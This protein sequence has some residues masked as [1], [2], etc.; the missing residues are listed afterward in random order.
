[1]NPH[2]RDLIK[3]SGVYAIG[4]I[5]TR[6]VS[7][8]ML[9][10]NTRFL[11]PADYGT[12]A[13][14]DLT[15]AILGIVFAGGM[16]SALGRFHHDGDTDE[17]RNVVWWTGLT[18][19]A[20]MTAAFVLPA[21]V[22]RDWI[23]RVTL[24]ADTV[25]AGL[26]YAL[27]LSTLWF[28]VIT[29]VAGLYL[30]IR[31]W[32]WSAVTLGV[33]TLIVNVVLNIYFLRAGWGIT[34]I[35]AGNL[36]TLIVMSVVRLWIVLPYCGRFRFDRDI[37]WQMLRFGLPIM[38][39]SLL[40]TAMQQSDR[41]LL[42]KYVDLESVGVYFLAY[43]IGQGLN[44]LVIGPFTAIWG[45]V[46]FDIARQ[47][48]SKA[49]FARIFEYY[50]Y[51]VLLLMFGVSLFIEPM[52]TLF[53]TPAYLGAAP[54]VPVVCLAL[55]FS[56]LDMHF[57]VPAI[58]A[59]QTLTLLPPTLAGVGLSI[60]LNIWLLPIFGVK[61]AP[62]I[63][64]GSYAVFAGATL[65]QARRIDRYQYPLLRCGS[66]LVA[67]VVSY[68][69]SNYVMQSTAVPALSVAVPL[70][71]WLAWAGMLTYPLLKRFGRPALVA[72]GWPA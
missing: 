49:T 32:S 47:P 34:G 41:Y 68:V 29:N 48:D 37:G 46:L 33:L 28:N 58:L 13:I 54:L 51:G 1:M 69:A 40:G 43:Q 16:T 52:I 65:V 26:Y 11:T 21:L 22:F 56:S 71:V 42:R 12:I 19:V 27:V 45:T 3:H 18:M 44:S 31:K 67:M 61:A 39:I 2:Y 55:V 20:A 4:T 72:A 63:S 70:V 57:R 60:A 66:V 5:L 14:L 64:V 53:A 9:P 10:I 23:A 50:V 8:V 35:L 7:I 24:G 36:I 30:R 17:H 59:K 38:L 6:I 15:A 25:N 62:W